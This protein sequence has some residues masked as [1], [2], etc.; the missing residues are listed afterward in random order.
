MPSRSL[1]P[2]QTAVSIHPLPSSHEA[3]PGETSVLHRR[4]SFLRH[5]N[6]LWKGTQ[7]FTTAR[8][9]LIVD[10]KVLHP[11]Q[12]GSRQVIACPPRLRPPA[13]RAQR[14][15]RS[16]RRPLLISHSL[17]H[18][19]RSRHPFLSPAT[20]KMPVGPGSQFQAPRPGMCPSVL[21]RAC[22]LICPVQAA[23]SLSWDHAK[24]MS[25]FLRI[26]GYPAWPRRHPW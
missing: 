12:R 14:S 16:P 7:Y 2:P 3:N 8:R 1:I 22:T 18:L 23:P 20:T 9:E 10:S 25:L 24:S 15:Y 6:G 21:H 13:G 11:A 4:M 17:P 19:L 26:P 5:V